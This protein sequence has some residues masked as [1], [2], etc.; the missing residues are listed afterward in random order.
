MDFNKEE[1]QT[2]G[3][4]SKV[5]KKGNIILR[6][7]K[8]WSHTVQRLLLYL[9][10]KEFPYSP[11]F[12]GTD[13]EGREMLSYMEGVC[14][15]EYPAD[16]S[17]RFRI[18]TIRKLG[19][20]LRRYHDITSTFSRSKE[21]VWMLSYEGKLEKEVICHNDIAPYNVTFINNIPV[22]LIDFDTCCPGPRIWDIAYALY[23][24]VPL[25]SEVYEPE[26]GRKRSYEKGRDAGIRRMCVNDFFRAYGIEKP[27]DLAEQIVKRLESLADYIASEAG[28]GNE[29]FEKMLEEGHQKIYLQDAEFIREHQ[30]EW[31]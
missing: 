31:F 14:M 7:Q 24:F 20:M 1:Q 15:E 29:V 9:E 18:S 10:K 2:G 25:T 5:W 13:E 11:R 8:S 28:K 3:N 21:D 26:T 23:R 22:G 30:S 19:E 27:D 4:V 16:S 12:L 17:I 6:E